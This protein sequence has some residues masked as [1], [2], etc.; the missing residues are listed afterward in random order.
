MSMVEDTAAR[1]GTRRSVYGKGVLEE[2]CERI[3]A[4]E[5]ILQITKDP[6]MPNQR[7][8]YKAMARDERVGSEISRARSFAADA[9]ADQIYGLLASANADNWQVKRTQ[10]W[11]LQ[12]YMGKVAPKKYGPPKEVDDEPNTLRVVVE[13][14]LPPDEPPTLELTASHPDSNEHASD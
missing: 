7:E 2:L 5:S 8:I 10:V 12:W 11:G 6:T 3:V 1:M 9:M 14:G 13:G 4:G